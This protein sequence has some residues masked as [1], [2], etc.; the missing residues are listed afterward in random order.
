MLSLLVAIHVH[1]GGLLLALSQPL[2]AARL[3]LE[4]V[5]QPLPSPSPSATPATFGAGVFSFSFLLSPMIWGPALMA[6][7]IGLMPNPRGRYERWFLGI[8]LATSISVLGLTLIGYQQFQAFTTGLQFEEKLPWLPA[9]GISYHLGVDGIGVSMLLL[10]ALVGVCGVVA[11]WEVRDR[12]RSYFALL[13][14]LE[15]AINGAVVARDFFLFFLFWSAAAVPLAL[16]VAGWSDSRRS[17]GAV[18]RLLGH[19][20]LGSAALLTAGLLLYRAAGGSDF[21]LDTLTRATPSARVE[22]VIAILLVVAAA[23]RLPL[24]P[25]HG[26]AREVLAEAP[27]GVAILATGAAAR[28]GGYVLIR[29]MAA[30]EHNASRTVAPYLAGLAVLTVG[31]AALA[32]FRSR[33]VRR[34]GAYLALV[35]GAITTLGVAGLSP[36]SL[37]GAVL[38]LFAGGLAA[39]LV[40]G[41][42]ATLSERAQTRSLTLAAGLAG[43]APKLAWLLLAGAVSVLCVPFLATF[44]A[45]LMI[46][47][48]SFRYQPVAS[49]LVAGGLVLCAAAVGWMLHRVLFG[50]ANPDAPS[51][52]DASLSESWYLGILVGTLLW[53][54]LV[55]SG[56]KLFGVPLF[57]PGL[58]TVVNSSTPDLTSPYAVPTPTPT[59]SATPKASPSPGVGPSPA[60]SPGASPSPAP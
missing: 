54:G 31:Y 22:L 43:R 15:A 53:V 21:D 2:A 34:L 45:G 48:G 17:P 47:L 25:L 32:A 19:W 27:A 6:V 16:L 60:V 35:P 58:V 59:P 28:L 18:W 38:S 49:F 3:W 51:A 13:L 14:L 10:S 8:A 11:S 1:G 55:P 12:P 5:G 40:V 41:A 36:L 52:A 20:G 4:T 29:L 42:T 7:V 44:P 46:F 39:A 30:G 50:A 9:L 33:D 23:S 26:W 57:D 56:P 37:E 24:V